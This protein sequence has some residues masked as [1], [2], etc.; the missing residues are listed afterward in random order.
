MA[1]ARR[2]AK[3]DR[4][5]VRAA[6]ADYL[7]AHPCVGCGETD[8]LLLDFDHR[9]GSLKKAP[10]SRLM[11]LGVTAIMREIEKCDIGCGNGHRK[12]TTTQLNW[13]K[14]PASRTP[15]ALRSRRCVER[16]GPR[17]AGSR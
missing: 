4:S 5:R 8:I 11:S 13:R 6:V 3:Q 2:R 1:R 17:R 14:S 12:G 7:R 15:A 16:H 10:V 9:D